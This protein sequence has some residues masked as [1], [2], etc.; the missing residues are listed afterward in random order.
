MRHAKGFPAFLSVAALVTA[1]TTARPADAQL[2]PDPVPVLPGERVLFPGPRRLGLDGLSADPSTIGD[3]R[4]LVAVAYVRSRIR[5]AAGRRA[6]M[7]NDVRVFQGDYV[8]A[9]GVERR[10]TFAFV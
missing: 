9:D 1:V 8:A 2:R 10:G 5:D 7:A 4:G 6:I 3:F